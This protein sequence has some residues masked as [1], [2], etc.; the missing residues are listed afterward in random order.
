MVCR[1]SSRRGR[2]SAEQ[3]QKLFPRP[4]I[5][6]E[7]DGTLLRWDAPDTALDKVNLPWTSTRLWGKQ[8]EPGKAPS[9]KA[10]EAK[11]KDKTGI[12]LGYLKYDE[13]KM[14]DDDQEVKVRR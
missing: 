8:G 7:I 3:A 11:V 13:K 9:L 4:F 10:Y 2:S 1:T 5:D 12:I 14:Q 6:S